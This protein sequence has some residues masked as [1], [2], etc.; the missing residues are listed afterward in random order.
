MKLCVQIFENKYKEKNIYSN[1]RKNQVNHV[2]FF[3]TYKHKYKRS[4][5][6]WQA[7]VEECLKE[8]SE[9]KYN[10]IYA[11]SEWISVPKMQFYLWPCTSFFMAVFLSVSPS[12]VNNLGANFTLELFSSTT[13]FFLNKKYE[14]TC[15]L[16]RS[17]IPFLFFKLQ[18]NKKVLH[19]QT[20]ML[21]EMNRH[22]FWV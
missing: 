20:D 5:F 21:I 9:S 3:F 18:P 19:H 14:N 8:K 16:W 2:F 13:F 22:G 6:T 17:F 10:N 12:L 4:L 1:K 15:G 7:I 11:A